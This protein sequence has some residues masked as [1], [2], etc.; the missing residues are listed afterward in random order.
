MTLKFAITSS[1]LIA[2]IGSF[3][4]VGTAFAVAT[5]KADNGAVILNVPI[6]EVG[7]GSILECIPVELGEGDY[8]Y[9]NSDCSG[10]P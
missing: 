3:L 6:G 9:A 8:G 4:A 10:E 2:V 5:P 7:A 1:A